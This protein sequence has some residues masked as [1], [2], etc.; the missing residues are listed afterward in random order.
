MVEDLFQRDR[1]ETDRQ[2]ENFATVKFC[3]KP[4]TVKFS[5]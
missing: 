3:T 5:I 2:T 4:L 1:R